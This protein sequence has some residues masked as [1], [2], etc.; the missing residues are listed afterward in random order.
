M[1]LSKFVSAVNELKEKGVARIEAAGYNCSEDVSD[2]DVDFTVELGGMASFME[3]LSKNSVKNVFYQVGMRDVSDFLVTPEV[4][5]LAKASFGKLHPSCPCRCD[6]DVDKYNSYVFELFRH[7]PEC[8]R[9]FVFVD[10]LV[11]GTYFFLMTLKEYDVLLTG[12]DWVLKQLCCG[13]GVRFDNDRVGADSGNV[14]DSFAPD[15]MDDILFVMMPYI[16]DGSDN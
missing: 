3:F 13:A 10:G 6:M 9:F 11:V 15:D 7:C 2:R 16:A 1:S 5:E 14:V 4:V 12:H 8:L